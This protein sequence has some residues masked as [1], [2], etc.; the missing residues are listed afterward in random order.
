[1]EKEILVEYTAEKCERWQ[2]KIREINISPNPVNTSTMKVEIVDDWVDNPHYQI[3][4]LNQYGEIKLIR[5]TT[6][7]VN[8][9]DTYFFPQGI[10]YVKVL[11]EDGV[12]SS[13]FVV[14]N[15]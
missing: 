13:I 7:K 2:P 10:Y 12:T 8:T 9:F 1:M 6:E 3:M 5:E 11:A 14:Q 15:N 4:I